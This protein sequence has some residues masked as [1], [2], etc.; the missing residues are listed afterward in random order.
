LI[1]KATEL[2]PKNRQ[3]LNLLGAI[4][5]DLSAQ[6]GDRAK[7]TQLLIDSAN[8]MRKLKAIDN[9]LRPREKRLF[10]EA[11]Y[12]EATAYAVEKKD[13]KAMASLSDVVAAGF[14][15]AKLLANDADFAS[16]RK[17]PDFA[18]LTAKMEV[19]A[20]KE[21][22]EFMVSIKAELKSFKSFPF[23]FD[24]PDLEAKSVKL[25][26]FKGKV[27]IVDVWGTWCPPCREEIPHFVELNKKY[28]DKGL[29][30]VGINYEHGEKSDWKKVISSFVKENQINYPCVIGD[31]KTRE[32]IP[33]FEGFP[34]TLFLDRDGKVRFKLVGAPPA[35]MLEAIVKVLLDESAT[36]TAAH[37]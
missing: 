25:A 20:R 4:T 23:T 26:D 16:I 1:Q 12:N 15:D 14:S 2:E 36:K 13:D 35:S 31:D 18:A 27:T 9:T 37:P 7:K 10:I 30:I 21:L 6:A 24:L 8:A 5:L 17:R 29:A 22:D 34:T 33:E 3:A 19:A 11:L 28:K 32:S